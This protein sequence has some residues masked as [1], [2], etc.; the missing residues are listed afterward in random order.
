MAK[1]LF[2]QILSQMVNLLKTLPSFT[3][4]RMQDADERYLG[5]IGRKWQKES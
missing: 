3:T 1:N 4:S 2:E 5:R